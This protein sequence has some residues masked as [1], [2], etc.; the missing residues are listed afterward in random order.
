[1]LVNALVILKQL[2]IW[3]LLAKTAEQMSSGSASI[4]KMISTASAHQGLCHCC[5]WLLIPGLRHL[6]LD[7]QGAH[8]CKSSIN[9]VL[10]KWQVLTQ[11]LLLIPLIPYTIGSFRNLE[12]IAH[13]LNFLSPISPCPSLTP[14]ISHSPF[15]RSPFIFLSHSFSFR[16]SLNQR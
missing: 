4:R 11:L 7:T 1:M 15:I 13:Y 14:Y 3:P 10:D 12:K 6:M 9:Y 2:P 5:W 16:F 8:V